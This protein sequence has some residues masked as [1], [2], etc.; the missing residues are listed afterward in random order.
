MTRRMEAGEASFSEHRNRVSVQELAIDDTRCRCRDIEARFLDA[1]SCIRSGVLEQLQA[2][3][4]AHV[5]QE[6]EALGN[7]FDEKFDAV[8]KHFEDLFGEVMKCAVI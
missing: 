7:V 6:V 2:A 8:G 4:E 1:C 5:E 3:I